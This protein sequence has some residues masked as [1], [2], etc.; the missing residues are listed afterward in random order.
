MCIRDRDYLALSNFASNSAYL[1]PKMMVTTTDKIKSFE[2]LVSWLQT[3]IDVY[4]RQILNYI[5]TQIML[6]LLLENQVRYI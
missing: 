6:I 4:K 2:N 5:L 3:S 1:E